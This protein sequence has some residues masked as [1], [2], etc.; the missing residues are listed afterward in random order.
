M[1][2][3][4]TQTMLIMLTEKLEIYK[5]LYSEYIANAVDLHNYHQT[6]MN[7]RGN[8]S[9]RDVR[10]ALKDMIILERKLYHA[11][12]DARKEQKINTE[13]QRARL[14]ELRKLAKPRP[15]PVHKGKKK[16]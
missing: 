13:A 9:C 7:N 4:V 16:K 2:L 1:V 12:L 6:F 11:T 15:L 3:P 14:K 5:R 10:R 8:D